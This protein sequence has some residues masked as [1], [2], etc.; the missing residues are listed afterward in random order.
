MGEEVRKHP[1]IICRCRDVTLDDVLKAIDEG[2][3]D[4]ECVKRRL[5][6]GMGPCQGRTCIPLVIGIMARRLGKKPD[7]LLIPKPRAP[8]TPI[9]VSLFL[10]SVDVKDEGKGGDE[11]A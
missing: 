2:C 7:E 8:V 11:N 3:E 9:P 5:G 6:L 10:K 1:I 4:L